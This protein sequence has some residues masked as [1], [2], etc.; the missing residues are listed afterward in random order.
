MI[1]EMDEHIKFHKLWFSLHKEIQHG[2]WHNKVNPEIS[3]LWMVIASAEIIEIAQSVTE[4]G[5]RSKNKQKETSPVVGSAATAPD[6]EH[7][8]KE[9]ERGCLTKKH[10][11]ES[12]RDQQPQEE[13]SQSTLEGPYCSRPAK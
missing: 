13:S 5:P 6:G 2:L 8:P 11:K 9:Q 1:R 4:G 7:Q 10:Q 3:S 12:L